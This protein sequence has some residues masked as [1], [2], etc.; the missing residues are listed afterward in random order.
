[1]VTVNDLPLRYWSSGYGT[2]CPEYVLDLKEV[3]QMQLIDDHIRVVLRGGG[4]V[5]DIKLEGKAA[6]N[7]RETY[8]QLILQWIMVNK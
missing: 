3:A 1:M 7:I 6:R 4:Y 2:D 8:E 5:M